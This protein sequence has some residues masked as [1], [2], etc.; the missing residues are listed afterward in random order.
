MKKKVIACCADT[1]EVWAY[2]CRGDPDFTHF[3]YITCQIGRHEL[4]QI[5][6]ESIRFRILTVD[7]QRK[8]FTVTKQGFKP[9]GRAER[10]PGLANYRNQFVFFVAYNGNYR[11]DIHAFAWQKVPYLTHARAAASVCTLA[12]NVYVFGGSD[13]RNFQHSIEVLSNPAA[14]STDL[15][16]ILKWSV[17]KLAEDFSAPSFNAAFVALNTDELF[18]FEGITSSNFV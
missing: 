7:Y 1:G 6:N 14:H 9:P 3:E 13:N 8:S 18:I 15:R 17:I 4:F 12:D 5:K 11:Y 2:E 10:D 16:T